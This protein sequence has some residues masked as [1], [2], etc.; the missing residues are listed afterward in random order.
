M[1]LGT[2]D[3]SWCQED[4]ERGALFAREYAA[5]LKEIRGHNPKARILCILGEMGTGLNAMMQRAAEEY[6]RETGDGQVRVLLLEEQNGARDGYGSDFHPNEISQRL[7]ANKVT[8]AIRRWM[9]P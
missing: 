6:C 3:L 9:K 5:F 7:L 8:D 2:N 4:P 1:N